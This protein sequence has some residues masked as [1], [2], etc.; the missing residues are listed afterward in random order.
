MARS[1]L[2]RIRLLCWGFALVVLA[3]ACTGG[4][5]ETGAPDAVGE[6]QTSADAFAAA[7]VNFLANMVGHLQ[8]SN[9][10]ADLAPRAASPELVQLADQVK[11]AA[12][13]QAQQVR[14]LLD[15][16]EARDAIEG[17]PPDGQLPGGA[18]DVELQALDDLRGEQFDR[19]F[20]DLMTRHQQAAVD[21][22][23]RTIEAGDSPEVADVATQVIDTGQDAIGQMGALQQQWGTPLAPVAPE[24]LGPGQRGP[25]VF[26]LERRLD[27]LR[28]DVG[29]VDDVYDART[30]HAVIA[31]QKV[32]GLPTS[33]RAGQ[34]TV[35]R[36]T[37]AQLP[38][39]LVP[40]GGPTRVEIDLTRQVLLFYQDGSLFKVLPV[41]TGSGERYCEE[42]DCGIATT[43]A[44]A[45]QV[46]W[47][48][49]GWRKSRLGR[50]YKP[51]YFHDRAGIA[52]HGY[53]SVPP[54]PASHG[55]VRI[56]IFSAEWFFEE[57]PRGAPVYVLD[58]KTPVSPL[59]PTPPQ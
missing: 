46:T 8:R 24:G 44:G 36:L 53:P 45:F 3:S 12:D 21:A 4:R 7:D 15:E 20:A 32:S 28:F 33:G 23:E 51:V 40:D 35:D 6:Q 38:P 54:Y 11:T 18:T 10:L 47:R 31:F 5:S 2:P 16:P 43:P 34:E 27:A 1:V 48:Y 14:R 30:T 9:E 58:G 39:P 25:Q 52:I 26:E 41:S 22:S 55:C 19:R 37:T 50:L 56:P 13:Q 17:A 49:P 57:V 59:P 42:G 29:Q